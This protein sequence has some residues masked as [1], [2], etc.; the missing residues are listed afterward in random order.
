MQRTI[1]HSL[2]T[3]YDTYLPPFVPDELGSLSIFIEQIAVSR[4]QVRETMRGF[5][6]ALL[7]V[8]KSCETKLDNAAAMHNTQNTDMSSVET[9]RER[10]ATIQKLMDICTSIDIPDDYYEKICI[11]LRWAVVRLFQAILDLNNTVHSDTDRA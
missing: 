3:D 5:S 10:L 4:Q 2:A 6:P 11:T 9:Y 1:A 7:T 8:I